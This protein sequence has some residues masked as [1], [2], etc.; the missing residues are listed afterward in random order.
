MSDGEYEQDEPYEAYNEEGADEADDGGDDENDG[1]D[2]HA[3]GMSAAAALKK[4]GFLH[5][6]GNFNSGWQRRWFAFRDG[7]LKYYKS[8]G[9]RVVTGRSCILGIP[10]VFDYWPPHV[11]HHSRRTTRSAASSRSS[12]CT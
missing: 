5:K 2:A 11:A 12:R 8:M 1:G 4:E 7:A 3:E 10:H 9:V 6:Q